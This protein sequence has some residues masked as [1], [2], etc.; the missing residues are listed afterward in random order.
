MYIQ[1][2]TIQSMIYYGFLNMTKSLH[3]SMYFI[4]IIKHVN[5]LTP[6]LTS[7]H[8]YIYTYKL[9]IYA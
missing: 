7:T 8:A 2:L 9:I 4:H 5:T 1:H 3:T 6:K